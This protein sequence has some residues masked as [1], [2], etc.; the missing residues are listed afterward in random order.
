MNLFENLQMMNENNSD[1]VIKL[2][3]IYMDDFDVKERIDIAKKYYNVD[4]KY[5]IN[6]DYDSYITIS[7][8]PENV[9]IYINNEY[10]RFEDVVSDY[11]DELRNA[12]N[13]YNPNASED[14]INNF[15]SI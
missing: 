12:Y 7:G 13:K 11:E 1:F 2:S 9:K 15:L 10:A 3:C 6:S 5:D 4:I 8:S 14:E